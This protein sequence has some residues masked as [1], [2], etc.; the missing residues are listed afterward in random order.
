VYDEP[1][2]LP[3][4]VRDWLGALLLAA[5]R[6][7]EAER[8]FREGLEKRPHNGWSLS[9]LEKAL[10]AQGRHAEADRAR[11]DFQRAW[12]RSDTWLPASRF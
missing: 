4:A 5:G 8:V 10:R 6:P 9:G 12:A 7:A 11:G 1:E 2:P 3:F